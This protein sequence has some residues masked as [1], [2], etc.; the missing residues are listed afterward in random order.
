MI[1]AVRA[2]R[3]AGARLGAG[4]V[5]TAADVDAAAAAGAHFVVT[6]AVA[7]S[8]AAAAER[9]IPCA[10]GALTATEAYAAMAAGAS[11]VKLLPASLGRTGLPQGTP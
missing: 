5:L 9:A 11:V 6:P 10:A 8:V 1:A 3:R 7:P 4:T 2:A